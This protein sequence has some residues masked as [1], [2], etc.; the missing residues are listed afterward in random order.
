[1]L[2][3]SQYEKTHLQYWVYKKNSHVSGPVRFRLM[4]Y[5][6]R[7]GVSFIIFE[8]GAMVR[9]KNS[10]TSVMT[11]VGKWNTLHIAGPHSTQQILAVD[12][13]GNGRCPDGGEQDIKYRG[14]RKTE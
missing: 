11:A 7:L 6:G 14:C 4:L 13:I 8:M 1:M 12:I 10:S 5:K 9:N 3:K 2:R